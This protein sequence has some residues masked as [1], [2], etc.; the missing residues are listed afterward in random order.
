MPPTGWTSA[1]AVEFS[2]SRQLIEGTHESFDEWAQRI[3]GE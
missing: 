3:P 2:R 1:Y